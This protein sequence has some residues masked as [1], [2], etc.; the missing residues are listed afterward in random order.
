VDE[1]DLTVRCEARLGKTLRGKWRLDRILGVGGM[2]AVYA[3]SHRNGAAAAIKILHAEIAAQP[4]A[5]ERF[6][7]EAYIA[8]RAGH[9][10]IVAVMDDDVD[11]D[12]AP[13][14]VMELLSGE[15][16]AARADRSGGRL[17][18]SLALWIANETLGVLEAAHRNGIVHRDIKPENLFLTDAQKVK[19]LDFGIARL[20]EQASSKKT[21]TG[22]LLGTPGYMAPEQALG[23]WE[24]VDARTDIW[25]VGATIF[26]L[27]SGEDVHEGSTD[28]VRVIHAATR[29]ARSLARVLPDAAPDLV[30]L[31]DKALE[32]DKKKRF[33]DA[34][35]MRTEIDR[36]VALAGVDGPSTGLGSGAPRTA[37][38]PTLADSR[39]S[40]PPSS[41]AAAIAMVEAER[42]AHAAHFQVDPIDTRIEALSHGEGLSG[43]RMRLEMR[44]L[45]E[46][47]EPGVRLAALRAI[48]KYSVRA[49]GPS[50][51]LRIRR[52]TFDLI[53]IEERRQAL[54]TLNALMPSRAEA[55][56]IELLLDNRIVSS[57][58]HEQTRE[59]AADLLA[60]HGTTE[61]ARAAL[62]TASRGR[63][64]NSERVRMAAAR[65]LQGWEVRSSRT[66]PVPPALSA[67]PSLLPQTRK[68]S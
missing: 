25:A 41:S 54:E 63:W 36:I 12:G 43:E 44:A 7:R 34:R 5:R 58:A 27:L 26:N 4:D 64:R 31:V 19:V 49:A 1:D 68:S 29:P 16:A 62:V 65:G 50:I 47:S 59:A 11:D 17:P 48:A 60:R 38:A 9:E 61:E 67:A 42:G 13:Y 45:L 51:V 35:S 40:I 6:L 18:V 66:T 46:D 28:N 10:G 55:V 15:T 52:Q 57:E 3:G 8:N 21:R 23:R 14:L 32:F 2:A 20:R 22:L 37:T 56:G 24:Q 30:K 33:P 53:P 39:G